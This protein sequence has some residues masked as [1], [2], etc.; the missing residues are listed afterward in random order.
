MGINV[1]AQDDNV[2]ADSNLAQ[3]N[4]PLA[5]MTAL[6]FHNY[7]IPKLN[8]APEYVD[9]NTSWIR[10]AKPFAGGKLLLR[11]SALLV[12][13]PEAPLANGGWQMKSGL[14][15]IKA[16]LFYS[17]ISEPTKTIG[18]GPLISAPTETEDG[19]GAG[20]WQ[21]GYANVAFVAKSPLIQ[22]GY[23]LTWQASF[24]GDEDRNDK[25]ICFSV[26]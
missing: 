21:A 22:Y 26:I 7:Y 19:L 25:F 20:K 24:A 5:K 23:L 2:S 18:I 3:A 16:F 1:Q 12:T 17:F 15:E 10:F 4:N 6:N 13:K 11:I 9:L 8:E 14:G